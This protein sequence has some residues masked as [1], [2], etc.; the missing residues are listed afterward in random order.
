MDFCGILESSEDGSKIAKA[1]HDCPI[2]ES[3]IFGT[4]I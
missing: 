2:S 3:D 1:I 4:Y